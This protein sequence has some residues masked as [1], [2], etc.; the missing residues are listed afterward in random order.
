MMPR[1]APPSPHPTK[2]KGGKKDIANKK[3]LASKLTLAQMTIPRV[4]DKNHGVNLATFRDRILACESPTDSATTLTYQTS[5]S[6][7]ER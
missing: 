5:S 2:M 1:S 6:L 7:K 4:V 3:K